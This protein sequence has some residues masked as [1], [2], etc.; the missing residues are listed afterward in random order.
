MSLLIVIIVVVFFIIIFIFIIIMLSMPVCHSWKSILTLS[1]TRLAMHI[2]HV[3]SNAFVAGSA[4][5]GA[6]KK[7]QRGSLP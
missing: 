4:D 5:S 6:A 7:Q 3:H 1:I 2:G